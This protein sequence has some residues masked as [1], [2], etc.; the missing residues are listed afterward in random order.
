MSIALRVKQLREA[1]GLRQNYVAQ[2]MGTSQQSYNM[3]ERNADL[4][5]V[6]TLKR[7]CSLLDVELSFLMAEDIPVTEE[8]L[9]KY[10]KRKYNDLIKDYEKYRNIFSDIS[11]MS[12]FATA[13]NTKASP[14][15]SF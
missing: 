11:L 2:A 12:H 3:F 10:G 9:I 8:N 4:A 15:A 1:K 13:A 7:F 5:K 14:Q 6:K